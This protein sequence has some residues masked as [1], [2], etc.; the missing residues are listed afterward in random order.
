MS[1]KLRGSRREPRHPPL[2]EKCRGLIFAT[3]QISATDTRANRSTER[4]ALLHMYYGR[5][6]RA[7]RMRPCPADT[8]TGNGD[9][10]GPADLARSRGYTRAALSKPRFAYA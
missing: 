4:L 2:V 8:R 9:P 5:P 1:E 6:L 3:L 7:I 10:G